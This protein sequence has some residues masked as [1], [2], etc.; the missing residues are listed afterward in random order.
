MGKK[1]HE[2]NDQQF[3]RIIDDLKSLPKVD[4]PDDFE[5]KLM[6]RIQNGQFE[7]KDSKI[8]SGKMW[9][10]IPGAAI[11]LS[12]IIIFFI[13]QETSVEFENPYIIESEQEYDMAF[14][15]PDTI[16]IDTN[17][18]EAEDNYRVVLQPN[19]ALKKEKIT[20]SNSPNRGQSVDSYLDGSRSQRG[21]SNPA[22]LVRAP[23]RFPE[24][25]FYIEQNRREIRKLK[26]RMDSLINTETKNR[27]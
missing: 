21:A 16:N 11:A 26:A 13:V 6:I 18:P 27:R 8:N 15:T 4:A 25:G 19:D 20:R 12:A 2:Q 5:Y 22:T 10:L 17:L 3:K 9:G 14:L 23:V 24:S 1:N 7:S